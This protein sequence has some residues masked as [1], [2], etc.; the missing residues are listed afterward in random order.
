MRS[1]LVILFIFIVFTSLSALSVSELLNSKDVIG[2]IYQHNLYLMDVNTGYDIQLIS[3]NLVESFCWD[4]TGSRIYYLQRDRATNVLSGFKLSLPDLQVNK[5][6][7][8]KIVLPMEST[9]L[10]VEHLEI[11][12]SPDWG[13]HVMYGFGLGYVSESFEYAYQ[14]KT[15]KLR[16]MNW[17]KG[18]SM[19]IYEPFPV[20]YTTD[21]DTK[22]ITR[23]SGK[24]LDLYVQNNTENQLSQNQDNYRRLSDTRDIDRE[25]LFTDGEFSYNI[26][27]DNQSVV[28]GFEE[29]SADLMHGRTYIVNMDGSHQ[30]L[31]NLDCIPGNNFQF[32][33]TSDNRL[34]YVS[35]TDLSAQQQPGWATAYD[36]AIKIRDALGEIVTIKNFGE[37]YITMHYRL[38]KLEMADRELNPTRTFNEADYYIVKFDD[39]RIR[40]KPSLSA[41]TKTTISSGEELEYMNEKS[42][43][44]TSV[45][46]RGVAYNSHWYKVRTI[47]DLVGWIYGAAIE[48]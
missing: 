33:W 21:A 41:P 25:P 48:K 36:T 14:F 34:V 31:L 47:N 19:S 15:Q 18:H 7:E 13:I 30:Q 8:K 22:L 11:K 4:Y 39:M 37:E 29:F 20:M 16:L 2:Y 43:Q 1:L 45:T 24:Y 9:G 28:F 27:S 5:L 46:L 42:A 12:L 26:S 10:E 6:F 44:T 23:K 3:N 38:S 17:E 40:E 32:G 35:D